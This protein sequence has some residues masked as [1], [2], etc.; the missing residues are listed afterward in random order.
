MAYLE[1]ILPKRGSAGKLFDFKMAENVNKALLAL[2]WTSGFYQESETR[3]V[4][5]RN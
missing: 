2:Q 4:G 3:M 5:R 1:T